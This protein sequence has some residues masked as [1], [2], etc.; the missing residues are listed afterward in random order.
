MSGSNAHARVPK[1]ASFR[2]KSKVEDKEDVARAESELSRVGR[3]DERVGNHHRHRSK[4][5]HAERRGYHEHVK[6]VPSLVTTSIQ[7]PSPLFVIDQSGDRQNLVYGSIHRYDVPPFHRSGAGNILGARKGLKIDRDQTDDKRLSL[8][9]DWKKRN[10]KREKYV[11][12][13]N[14]KKAPKLLHFLPRSPSN[15]ND[16][17]TEVDFIP[18]RT[19][20][21]RKRKRRNS[22]ESS[23][24]DAQPNYRSIE[25]KCKARPEPPDES[26][27]Y[28]TESD[29]SDLE[30]SHKIMFDR[31][32]RQKAAELSRAVEAHPEDINAWLDLINHQ[33]HLLV[34][35]DEHRRK[36]T[37]AE[38]RSTADIKLHLYN[39][40]LEK[41]GRSLADRERLLLGMMEEG[42]KIWDFKT[43]SER[44]EHVS[45]ENLDSIVLWKY[46]LDFRQ[47]SFPMFRYEEIRNIFS[48]RIKLLRARIN[49]GANTVEETSLIYEHLVYTI[50]RATL[51]VREAG[52]SELALGIWQGL[53]ELNYFGPA[54]ET[55][56][57]LR[58]ELFH[59]FWE[60]EVSRVGEIDHGGWMEYLADN[61]LEAPE[62]RT[63]EAISTKITDSEDLFENW[64]NSER[65]IAKQSRQPARTMDEVAEN[66][67]FRV[68]LW[69]DIE[70]FLVDLPSESHSL[71][72]RRVLLD[73]YLLFCR[74]PPL[75]GERRSRF[76]S[77]DSFVRDEMLEWSKIWL[78]REFSVSAPVR[79]AEVVESVTESSPF[80]SS[81]CQFSAS[82]DT[83][84]PHNDWVNYFTPWRAIYGDTD[85]MV[86]MSYEWLRNTLKALIDVNICPEMAE[87]FLAFELQN[88]PQS[89]KKSAKLLLKKN[90]TSLKFYHAYAMTEF[91]K[92]NVETAITVIGAALGMQ[93]SA[94]EMERENSI[95]LWRSWVWILLS[96]GDTDESLK[97]LLS[98]PENSSAKV[99]N[100]DISSPACLLKTRQHLC[101]V[102]D[103]LLSSGNLDHAIIHAECLA[104]LEYVSSHRGSELS[105]K[106]QGD[107]EMA[108]NIFNDFSVN[109]VAR[110]H[111]G[112]VQH[113]LLHQAA[114]KL[115]YHH[116]RSGPFRPALIRDHLAKSLASFPRNTIFLSLYAWNESRLRIDDRV[117]TI[118]RDVILLPAVDSLTSRLF[119]IHHEMMHGNTHS[120]HAA[121]ENAVVSPACSSN[122]GLWRLYVLFCVGAREYRARAKDVFYKGMRA[123]PWAKW[124]YFMAFDEL[125]DLMG[126]EEKRSVYRILEEK[127]LRV[128]VDLEE[129]LE[130]QEA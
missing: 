124:F 98:I 99:A 130:E 93:A 118:L 12:A 4:D 83:L 85:D 102:R 60:A 20:Q 106:G 101:S 61:N 14:E 92:G 58:L 49:K 62:S 77:E 112:T 122:P 117:R 15:N 126:L 113:E 70:D 11:F 96:K 34:Q 127:E 68:I 13:H 91:S 64:A 103:Y 65:L 119:A 25:G 47:S 100:I 129:W 66:D 108:L 26:M 5:K 121:F 3:T 56:E 51:F 32:M 50:L 104:L 80:Q 79:G 31:A 107:I 42:S 27:Q 2:P 116:A 97:C 120:T 90:P 114:A 44:W 95:L 128:H 43:Q 69:S 7:T 81:C 18:L 52:Y 111:V 8:T 88:E 89:T 123:C 53:L 76:W 94:S 35:V 37:S 41:G 73:A 59:N 6:E 36:A 63:D 57:G 23:S 78:S 105:S 33:D 24:D 125:A 16:D 17:A 48:K 30:S 38:R 29:P 71:D 40:A 109:L 39:K 9:E 115:L 67:P 10:V 22:Q 75:P 21:L 45:Q 110:G 74:L 84:F 72:L 86:P 19:L 46:Y 55:V 54:Q 82:F 28:L 1:F 87:Y